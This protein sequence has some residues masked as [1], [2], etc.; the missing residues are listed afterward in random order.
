[1]WVHL[2]S[3][4]VL[5][6]CWARAGASMKSLAKLLTKHPLIAILTGV[7]T[8]IAVVVPVAQGVEIVYRWIFPELIEGLTIQGTVQQGIDPIP[9]SIVARV[10]WMG[11]RT[12]DPIWPSAEYFRVGSEQ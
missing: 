7:A 2:E 1:M 9:E 5:H 11:E 10:F 6:L 8:I 4:D 12:H 3:P